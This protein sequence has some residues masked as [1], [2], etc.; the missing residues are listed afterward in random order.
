MTDPVEAQLSELRRRLAALEAD[1]ASVH[2]RLSSL[3]EGR[4]AAA[5]E[6]EVAPAPALIETGAR[7]VDGAGVVGLFGRLLVVLGGAFLIRAL[8]ESPTFSTALGALVGLAYA[9]WWLSRADRAAA[10]GARLDA[11]F[12][13]FASALVAFPLIYEVTGR[14]RAFPVWVGAAVVVIAFAAWLRVAIR[15]EL[16][17]VAWTVTVLATGVCLGLVQ[18]TH[19]LVPATLALLG[20]ALLGEVLSL[21]RQW[22]GLRWPIALGVDLALALVVM[23]TVR[24]AGLP[25]S[26][27]P[28]TAA[29]AIGLELALA[30]LYLASVATRTLIRLRRISVFAMV[31][32]PTALVLGLGGAAWTAQRAGAS[33]AAVGALAL[34]LGVVSY[35]VALRFAARGEGTG[36]NFHF[37][38]NLA[39]PL[40]L[41]G[42]ATLLSGRALA[43]AWV[44]LA[45]VAAGAARRVDRATFSFQ[46]GVYALCGL[47]AAGALRMAWEGLAAPVSAAWQPTS[48]VAV[49]AAVGACVAF[50][51]VAGDSRARGWGIARGSLGALASLVFAGQLARFLIVAFTGGNGPGADAGLAAALRTA[52][53][54]AAALGLAAAGTW[55]LASTLSFLVTPLLVAGGLKLAVEDL[56]VGRPLTLFLSLVLYGGALLL[57]PRLQRRRAA[58]A[59]TE[60]D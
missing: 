38:A 34:V 25:E 15:R 8:S 53:I 37:Y 46:A 57:A 44:G 16:P 12:H 10:R 55:R 24:E 6:P 3:E 45:L 27:V 26:Y 20:L 14:F 50:V 31:Q 56:R 49:G 32:V 35:A 7:P 47:G 58:A 51:L 9:A 23:L 2:G 29:T 5:S 43:A 4:G 54:A 22:F 30:A 42:T 41:A 1:L 40:L 60:P 18:A 48:V 17:E 13:G 52:V 19:D 28:F 33:V 39:V 21:D 11:A 36:R 59:S